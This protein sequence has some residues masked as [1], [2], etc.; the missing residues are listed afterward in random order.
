MELAYL[1]QHVQKR[2]P[3]FSQPNKI[4]FSLRVPLTYQLVCSGLRFQSCAWFLSFPYSWQAVH[5]WV[6][7]AWHLHTP[8][9]W[10]LLTIPSTWL[11]SSLLPFLACWTTFTS[12]MLL[13][14]SVVHSYMVARMTIVRWLKMFPGLN[15]YKDFHF[16]IEMKPP[17]TGASKTLQLSLAFPCWPCPRTTV[18]G[19]LWT[20]LTLP[21]LC[22]SGT[23]NLS[24]S[25]VSFTCSSLRLEYSS[26]RFLHGCIFVI[27]HILVQF[28]L[29]APTPSKPVTHCSRHFLAAYFTAIFLW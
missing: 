21:F 9:I 29:R 25:W 4:S 6:M 18:P 5:S 15:S 11:L 26:P 10:L 3:D 13:F 8:D 12:K 20:S 17:L 19:I 1:T 7:S 14:F 16:W 27:S 2:T 22:A 28:Y 24:P 23:S